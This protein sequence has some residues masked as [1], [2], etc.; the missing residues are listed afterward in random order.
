[1]K[2]LFL[3]VVLTSMVITSCGQ[4]NGRASAQDQT[5]ASSETA[6][7]SVTVNAAEFAELIIDYTA[8]DWRFV[9]DQPVVLD[10]FATWCPPCKM[11]SPILEE[12]AAEYE[13][14]VRFYKVDVDQEPEL[15]KAFAIRSMP[16]LMF[17]P[18]NGEMLRASGFMPKDELTEV[19]ETYL[20][21][22]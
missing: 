1:M 6:A 19:I 16:T 12:L 14:K 22:E 10:F 5:K 18:M 15:A 17:I 7:G 11:L 20:L 9:G 8:D 13:G 4:S 3:A 2:K 21:V